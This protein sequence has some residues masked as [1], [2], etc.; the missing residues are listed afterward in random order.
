MKKTEIAK[1]KSM[2][3]TELS[4]GIVEDREKLRAMKFDLSGGKVKNVVAVRELKKK[5]AR[6]MT[7]IRQKQNAKQHQN[8]Q[9]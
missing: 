9:K 2:N 6:M 4:K 8:N 5:I 1:I 3:V 7:F